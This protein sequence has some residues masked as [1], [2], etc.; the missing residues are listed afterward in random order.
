[1]LHI[2]TLVIFNLQ[3]ILVA[4]WDRPLMGSSEEEGIILGGVGGKTH[5][6]CGLFYFLSFSLI[7]SGATIFKNIISCKPS[8]STYKLL[9]LYINLEK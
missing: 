6:G 7:L 5:L 3:S 8:N 2:L 9:I 1:M 4:P